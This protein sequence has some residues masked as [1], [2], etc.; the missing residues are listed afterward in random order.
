MDLVTI[1][2]YVL[3]SLVILI[4]MLTW[5]FNVHVKANKALDLSHENKQE[6]KAMSEKKDFK[7]DALSKDIN[8]VKILIAQQSG[9]LEAISKQLNQD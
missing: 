1:I 5:L 8:D 6:L 9:I 4:T 2:Y 3:A 7:I